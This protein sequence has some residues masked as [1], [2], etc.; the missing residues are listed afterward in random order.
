MKLTIREKRIILFCLVF[1]RYFIN[2]DILY[3]WENVPTDT[4][5]FNTELK[6]ASSITH[7]NRR[8]SNE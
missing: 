5:L 1:T 4:E 2:K 7:D 3:E 8:K 6:I